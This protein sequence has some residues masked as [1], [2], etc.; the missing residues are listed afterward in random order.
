MRG[1]FTT[2]GTTYTYTYVYS[3]TNKQ[4]NNT[5]QIH[6]EGKL[7]T[8]NVRPQNRLVSTHFESFRLNSLF[9]RQKMLYYVDDTRTTL[10]VK[11]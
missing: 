11:F 1:E 7:E 8:A 6:H 10:K 3:Y 4:V 5:D 9:I 2:Y